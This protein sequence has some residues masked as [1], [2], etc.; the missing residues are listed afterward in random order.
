MAFGNAPTLGLVILA[1]MLAGCSDRP[2]RSVSVDQEALTTSALPGSDPAK[3]QAWFGELHTHTSFSFDAYIYNVRGTPDD[4]YR[5]GKGEP[6]AHTSGAMI[7]ADRPLDFM[8]VTDHAEYLGAMRYLADPANDTGDSPYAKG[9]QQ[10]DKSVADAVFGDMANSLIHKQPIDSLRAPKIVNGAWRGLIEAAERHYLPGE[11]TTLIGYEWTSLPDSKNLHRNVIFRGGAA[12]VPDTPYSALDSWRPEDLWRFLDEY[13]AGGNEALAIPHNSNLSNGAMFP[14]DVDSWDR[15]LTA[16][17]AASRNRNEP[18]V[19]ISQ[20]KGTSETHPLL[21]P[22]DEWAGFEII[23]GLI[24]APG[25]TS[26]PQ[27][28]YARR[29]W[30][31]GLELAESAGFNPY[32]FGVIGASDSHNASATN[33]EQNYHGKTG[34]SDDT[35]ARRRVAETGGLVG[36]TYGAAGLAGVW[37]EEN[38]R[39]AIYDALAR[40]ETFATSGPRIRLRLFGGWAFASD[41]LDQADWVTQAYAQG[42]PMGSELSVTQKGRSPTFLAWAQQDP[43]GVPLQRLQII[44]GWVADGEA[45]ERVFDVACA[46][47]LTPDENHRCPDNGAGVDTTNCKLTYGPGSAELSAVWSDEDFRA[48]QPAFYYLRVIQNPTCRWSTWDAV[49]NG[50]PLLEDVP[51]TIAERAWSSPLWYRGNG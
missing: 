48:S 5:Y 35:V 21:S 40:K 20:I 49:R 39:E 45:Q 18:L 28:S 10:G 6:I 2:V 13:R 42:V 47:G 15:P 9:L 43:N 32:Q 22:N 37:A 4:A 16:S 44:K 41:L 27:G 25:A 26:E 51:A 33:E 17:Y 50:L 29:A 7:Q 3:R 46:D 14:N 24:G 30:L 12:E 31:D 36:R 8:A 11:F 38:T 1:S 23:D 34:I 19:E